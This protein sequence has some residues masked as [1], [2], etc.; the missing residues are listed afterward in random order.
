MK[1]QILILILI[2]S[3]L[4]I[5]AQINEK[6]AIEKDHIEFKKEYIYFKIYGLIEIEGHAFKNDTCQHPLFFKADLDGIDLFDDL[7]N[8]YKHRKCNIKECELI[9]LTKMDRIEFNSRLPY[10]QYYFRSSL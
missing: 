6:Q 7:G 2:L 8:K 10:P 5:K 1:T 9:H 4:S 3:S